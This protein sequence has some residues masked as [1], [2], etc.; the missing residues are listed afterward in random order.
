MPDCLITLAG[1]FSWSPRGALLSQ[2]NSAI[3]LLDGK[4]VEISNKDL[5]GKAQPY[6]IL[7][8]YE[9]LAYPNRNSVPFREAYQIPEAHTMIRG[10][11]RYERNPALVKALIDLGWLDSEKK[12]WLKDVMTWAQIQQHA[13]GAISTAEADLITKIDELCEFPSIKV[14]DQVISGL[15]WMGLFPTRC[16]LR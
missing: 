7:D 14:R 13:T 5:M 2:Y 8:G 11:L 6:H 3:F 10:S 15:E 16:R 9:F 12:S 1:Q 4:I